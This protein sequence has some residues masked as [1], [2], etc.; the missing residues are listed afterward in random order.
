MPKIFDLIEKHVKEGGQ[1]I[2]ILLG[3]ISKRNIK[4]M[5]GMFRLNRTTSVPKSLLR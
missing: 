4:V 3:K 1:N 2:K 5:D